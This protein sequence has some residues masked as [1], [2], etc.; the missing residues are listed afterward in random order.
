VDGSAPAAAVPF[1]LS[2][3]QVGSALTRL[4]TDGGRV[5]TARTGSPR[6]APSQSDLGENLLAVPTADAVLTVWMTC[7]VVAGPSRR[8]CSRDASREDSASTTSSSGPGWPRV[9]RNAVRT[10]CRSCGASPPG[11]LD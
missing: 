2:P 7:W 8:R 6:G 4:V 9:A 1:L 10:A 11:K 3:V 5:G